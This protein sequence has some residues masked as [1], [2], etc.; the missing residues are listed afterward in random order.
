MNHN[1]IKVGQKYKIIGIENSSGELRRKFLAMGLIPG[2]L[3]SVK[4]IAP[5][6]GAVEIETRGFWLI[7]RNRE[8]QTLSLE[9]L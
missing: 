6:G 5:F 7:L 1:K 3:L 4:R 8:L 9:K 2:A